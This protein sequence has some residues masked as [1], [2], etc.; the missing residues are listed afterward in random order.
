MYICIYTYMKV[1][2]LED[3]VIFNYERFPYKSRADIGVML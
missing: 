2:I 3:A 1:N